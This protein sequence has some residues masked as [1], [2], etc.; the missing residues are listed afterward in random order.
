[1]DL[2]YQCQYYKPYSYKVRKVYL[3][4][5]LAAYRREVLH[6]VGS[7]LNLKYNRQG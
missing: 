2:E 1:M 5:R 4:L 7:G 3:R 6:W